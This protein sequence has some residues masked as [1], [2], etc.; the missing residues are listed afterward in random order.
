MFFPLD[1]WIVGLKHCNHN[2][3][4]TILCFPSGATLK[5]RVSECDDIACFSFIFIPIIY[6]TLFCTVP[7]HSTP[8]PTPT[9]PICLD[10]CHALHPS[11]P[12]CLDRWLH[13]IHETYPTYNAYCHCWN[14]FHWLVS[15]DTALPVV[16]YPPVYK[17]ILDE[18]Y[19][20][21]WC[22]NPIDVF[23]VCPAL[24]LNLI[25]SDI[26]N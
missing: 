10:C 16:S 26:G 3:P 18:G 20:L 22:L 25:I 23:H 7:L 1:Q 8:F 19:V 15:W 17:L 2:N 4:S 13:T 9:S 12:P 24:Q 5:V 6:S 11:V 14:L 21:T